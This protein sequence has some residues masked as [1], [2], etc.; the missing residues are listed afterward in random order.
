MNDAAVARLWALRMGVAQ[1]TGLTEWADGPPP[2]VGWWNARVKRSKAKGLRRRWW[3]GSA[4]SIPVTVG[5][6]SDDDARL[7]QRTTSLV[8]PA[9]IQWQGLDWDGGEG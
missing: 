4:W 5:I 9:L 8:D 3:D 6:D 7:L 1:H 2:R